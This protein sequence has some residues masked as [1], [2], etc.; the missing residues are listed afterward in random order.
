M[1]VDATISNI[2]QISNLRGSNTNTPVQRR[3]LPQKQDSQPARPSETAQPVELLS[4]DELSMLQKLFPGQK[5][6]EAQDAGYSINRTK[7]Q[8]P[9]L[10]NF[11]DIKQ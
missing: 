5:N 9:K 10:G 3:E 8:I 2:T 7:S 11:I 4:S 1:K 6:D